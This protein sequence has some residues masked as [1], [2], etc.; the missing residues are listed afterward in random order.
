MKLRQKL[1][2][3]RFDQT[4][5][6]TV[7]QHTNLAKVCGW[8]GPG[9]FN[10]IAH[11][12]GWANIFRASGT[13]AKQAGGMVDLIR[14]II[15]FDWDSYHVH[16]FTHLLSLFSVPQAILLLLCYSCFSANFPHH[17]SHLF[18]MPNS[19]RITR[20]TTRHLSIDFECMGFITK[21]QTVCMAT[22]RAS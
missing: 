6:W 17:N 11:I 5:H 18:T 22:Y 14:S 12:C 10:N 15:D 21:D 7:V 4:L 16:I 9:Q 13:L 8:I 20:G 2:R 19:P 1:W 3:N